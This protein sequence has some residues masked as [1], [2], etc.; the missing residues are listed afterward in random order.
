[1]AAYAAT[2]T[3]N[4]KKAQKIAPG[5]GMITGRVA[6][7]NYNS[8]LAAIT[9]ISS[10]FK[11][12]YTVVASV[13][14]TGALPTWVTASKAFKCYVPNTGVEVANDVDCGTIDFVA[15]GRD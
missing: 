4:G 8:T 15:F 7:S 2:T 11:S 13:S 1:M 14:S 10:R 12:I 5:V 6:L 9:G 3:I